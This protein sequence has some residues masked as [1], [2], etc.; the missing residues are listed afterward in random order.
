MPRPPITNDGANDAN[1]AN[2][3]NASNG[4]NDDA[5]RLFRRAAYRRAMWPSWRSPARLEQGRR[6]ERLA[7]LSLRR[8]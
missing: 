5:T 1:G 3:H 7:P 6:W 2:H 4:A 8:P